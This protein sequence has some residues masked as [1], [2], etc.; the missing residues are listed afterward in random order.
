[1]LDYSDA[2]TFG[3]V[4]IAGGTIDLTNGAMIVTTSSFGFVPSGGQVNEY[5][6]P[7]VAEFG[8][9]AIHDALAEGANDTAALERHQRHP[10]QH[11]GQCSRQHG[12]GLDR[13]FD[14]SLHIVPR[15]N[16]RALARASSRKP[17]TATPT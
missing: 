12:R 14:R 2:K 8:D 1:M 11:G 5:G 16:G 6:S 17:I 7:G 15:P 9:A 3:S 4:H 13:R 10:Q